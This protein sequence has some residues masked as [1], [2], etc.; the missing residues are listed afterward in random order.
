M[1]P[2][3]LQAL[4]IA[5][6]LLS[7]LGR[8]EEAIDAAQ[9]C[10]ALI[11]KNSHTLSRLGSAQAKA[12]DTRAAQIVLQDMHEIASRRY[13]SPYH[14]ALVNCSLG[15]TEQ[16]LD[17]LDQAYESRDGKVLWMAVDPEFGALHGNPRFIELLA[18]LNHRLSPQ[19]AIQDFSVSDQ[20][21]ISAPSP[22]SANCNTASALAIPAPHTLDNAN[23]EAQQLYTAGRYY[24]TRRTAEGLWQAIDRLKHAVELDPKF[25]RAHA[26]LADCYALLNWYVEPPPADAW[27]LAKQSAINAVT[28]DPKL[29]EARASL[30]FVRLHYD[31]DWEGAERELRVAIQL[32]PGAQVAHRW[33]AFSLSTM[34]RHEEALAEMK[35]AREISPQSAV[36]ATA[37]ANVLFLAGRYDEAIEQCRRAMELDSGAVS[38]HTVLR[39]CYEKK[40]MHREALAA[41]EEERVFAGDTPT[42]RLK[43][44]SVLAA[45]DRCEEARMVLNE[46]IERRP[47]QWVSAYEI[48]IVY[49]WLDDK[50]SAFCWLEQAEREH[51]IG[52]TF[53]RV[54][55][56]LEGLRSDPR[57]ESLLRGI[58][59]TIP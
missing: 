3:N 5:S 23:Q 6:S 49:C 33:Y 24:S 22:A 48:A 30:G 12:G 50:D 4:L 42:T 58:D 10:V 31:R 16:T 38:V 19:S 29:A 28:A 54:D 7:S 17:L 18:K 45:V 40:G 32:K 25:A 26:E 21:A 52:F 56:R 39:W 57:F 36:L 11:G 15:R 44:A 51:A 37:M 53:V 14:L 47:V 20:E 46:V 2:N 13:I 35:R 55:P 1:Q 8:H 9:K 41:F 34:G 59:R 43:R 27:K